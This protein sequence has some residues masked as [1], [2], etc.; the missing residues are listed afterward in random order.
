MKRHSIVCNHNLHVT[1]SYHSQVLSRLILQPRQNVK[2]W[3]KPLTV[4]V[5][6]TNRHTCVTAG[7]SQHHCQQAETKRFSR[8]EWQDISPTIA[9]THTEIL[10]PQLLPKSFR[11]TGQSSAFQTSNVVIKQC[12]GT[13]TRPDCATGPK[14]CPQPSVDTSSR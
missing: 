1:L 3:L 11:S 13:Q 2:Q 9:G 12:L 4:P 5:R 7:C 8:W 14:K 10:L 6:P